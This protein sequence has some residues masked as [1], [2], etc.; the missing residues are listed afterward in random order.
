M[1]TLKFLQPVASKLP[2]DEWLNETN[3]TDMQTHGNARNTAGT[4]VSG[5]RCPMHV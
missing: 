3:R 4:N 5:Y 2:D 1:R